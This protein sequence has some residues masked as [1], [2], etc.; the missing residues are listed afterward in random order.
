[1]Q[2]MIINLYVTNKHIKRGQISRTVIDNHA[3]SF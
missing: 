3:P 1:M 2:E